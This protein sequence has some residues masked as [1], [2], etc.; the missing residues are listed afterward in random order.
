MT[1]EQL[2]MKI[3]VEQKMTVCLGVNGEFRVE[4][5][6]V[7][8]R[9]MLVDKIKGYEVECIATRSDRCIWAWL[10]EIK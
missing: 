9:R 6:Q 7:S 8:L 2:M 10:K 3:D 4:G 1:F 5:D